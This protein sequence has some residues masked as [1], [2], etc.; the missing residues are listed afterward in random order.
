L[1]YNSNIAD[2]SAN[3]E[4]KPKQWHLKPALKWIIP[5]DKRIMATDFDRVYFQLLGALPNA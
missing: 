5:P 4:N 2:K 3:T 1:R